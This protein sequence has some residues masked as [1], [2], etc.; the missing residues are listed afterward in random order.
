MIRALRTAATGMYAQELFV[1]V[2]ANNLANVNTTGFKRSKVEFQDLLY[3]TLQTP[4][5]ERGLANATNTEIQIGHG[6]RPVA[7][8]KQFSQGD[9][10]P[11][12]NP[13]DLAIE[14][15]GFFQVL[16]SDGTVAYTRDGAFKLN[17]EGQLVTSDGLLV[18]PSITLPVDTESINVST[19]G[20]ISVITTGNSEPEII[21]QLEL[22]KFINP[23]GLKAI[24]RN[25]YVPTVASGEPQFGTPE[26]EGFGRIMQG[27]LEL[28]NVDV[29]EE[30]ISLI[31]AQRSYE[32]NSKA[33]RTAEEMLSTANNLQR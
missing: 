23:A 25:L 10:N 11:T 8:V 26:S 24:G 5:V 6:T 3:Q 28:S 33:I 7:V 17:S 18:Q 31:V 1:D 19:D 32:I 15:D 14:G 9:V 21:G 13:L 4:G 12:G 2:I 16:L 29:V 20:V 27:Y 22:A 30:M